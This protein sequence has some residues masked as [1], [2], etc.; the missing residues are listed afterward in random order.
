MWDFEGKVALTPSCKN[1]AIRDTQL[2][3]GCHFD[4]SQ[5]VEILWN[6][7]GVNKQVISWFYR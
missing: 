1:P 5:K 3:C 2:L 6:V 4:T 7:A